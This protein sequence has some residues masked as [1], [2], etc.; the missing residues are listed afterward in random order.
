MPRL[1]FRVSESQE[2]QKP[3]VNWD[4]ISNITPTQ[5]VVDANTTKSATQESSTNSAQMQG[6]HLALVEST[7]Q[8]QFRMRKMSKKK[9]VAVATLAFSLFFGVRWW[10]GG[11]LPT[12]PADTFTPLY[13]VS[14]PN[15]NEA[16]IQSLT[17]TDESQTDAITQAY[18]TVMAEAGKTSEKEMVRLVA[19]NQPALDALHHGGKLPYY[20]D[21]Y[22]SYTGTYYKQPIQYPVQAGLEKPVP[23][24]VKVRAIARLANIEASLQAKQGEYNKAV[25][26][27]FD[28][29]KWGN[30][31]QQG[32]HNSLIEHMIGRLVKNIGVEAIR[33]QISDLTAQEARK[34]L[35]KNLIL[36]QFS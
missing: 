1:S 16:Y 22:P 17:L 27:G 32:T 28:I 7:Q 33:P 15:A 24:F 2:E 3:A 26:T 19:S 11:Q 9:K 25:T 12:L 23:D 29:L 34:R 36:L 20:A 30:D 35:C 18:D 8:R 31:L 14:G 21:Y 4:K 10:D 13:Q 6:Q 5:T